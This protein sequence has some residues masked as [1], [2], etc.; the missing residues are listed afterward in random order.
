MWMH[1]DKT[2][3]TDYQGKVKVDTGW[4]SSG[5]FFGMYCWKLIW[6]R[7]HTS[8]NCQRKCDLF[9]YQKAQIWAKFWPKLLHFSL[10]LILTHSYAIL[11]ILPRGWIRYL[12]MFV[13]H[14]WRVFCTD[15]LL[16]RLLGVGYLH[17]IFEHSS[18]SQ[19]FCS[20]LNTL[21]SKSL[22]HNMKL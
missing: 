17:L 21:Q 9:I 19:V 2:E 6:N 5:V 20:V 11:C 22:A 8:T 15:S 12:R 14:S 4:Y 18:C 1:W 16:P 3:Y 7:S 10:N 13:A